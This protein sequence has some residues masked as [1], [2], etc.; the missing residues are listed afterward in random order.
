VEDE[1]DARL[2]D[3]EHRDGEVDLFVDVGHVGS[4]GERGRQ[5]GQAARIR[6]RLGS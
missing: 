5:V 4:G 1:E 3:D 6:E 2:V